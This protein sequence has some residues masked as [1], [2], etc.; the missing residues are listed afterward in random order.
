M[1]K[2][3]CLMP[4]RYLSLV[5]FLAEIAGDDVCVFLCNCER[6]DLAPVGHAAF[7]CTLVVSWKFPIMCLVQTNSTVTVVSLM[8]RRGGRKCSLMAHRSLCLYAA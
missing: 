5:F 8:P 3:P 1:G 7:I 4:F 2:G 6:N